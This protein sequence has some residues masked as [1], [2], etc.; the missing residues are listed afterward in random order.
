MN[1]LKA[2]KCPS[3]LYGRGSYLYVEDKGDVWYTD[4]TI[5]SCISCSARAK[6]LQPPRYVTNSSQIQNPRSMTSSSTF[7][8]LRSTIHLPMSHPARLSLRAPPHLPFIQGF[9]GIPGGKDRKQAALCGTVEVRVGAQPIKA[10]G[11][12][13]NVGN[14][15]RSRLASRRRRKRTAGSS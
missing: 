9:P 13:S 2:D 15:S 1:H 5:S 4:S 6:Q 3:E 7:K 14:T 12:G 11:F 8:V 10:N